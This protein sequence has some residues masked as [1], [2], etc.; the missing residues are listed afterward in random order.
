MLKNCA[1]L[2]CIAL[3]LNA[4]ELSQLHLVGR[5]EKSET[6]FVGASV[7]DANGRT[8]A[9]IKVISDLDGFKYTSYNGVVK[10]DDLPGQDLVYISPDE[11]VLEVFHGGFEPLKLIFSE[12]G[13]APSERRIWA[14][15]VAG[16]NQ[17]S[18]ALSIGILVTPPGAEVFIDGQN[19]GTGEQ[20]AVSAGS[21]QLRLVKSGYQPVEETIQV[22]DKRILFKYTMKELEPVNVRVETEPIGAKVFVDGSLLGESPA[23][24]FLPPGRYPLRIEKEWY[25][26]LEELLDI[27]P[28]RVKKLYNLQPTFAELRVT[29]APISGLAIYLDGVKQTAST[30]A[31]LKPLRPGAYKVEA[32]SPD[33][34]AT[35]VVEVTLKQGEQREVALTSMPSYALLT[36]RS[37]LGAKVTLNGTEL[38]MFENIRLQPALVTVRAEMAKAAPVER[39]IM[40]R[41]GDNQ[42]IELIPEVPRGTI[43][44]SAV[45]EQAQIEL[46]GDAGEFY[47]AKG[48]AIFTNIPVGRYALEVKH[49]GYVAARENLRLNQG[50][51]IIRNIRLEMTAPAS[52]VSGRTTAVEQAGVNTAQL[53]AIAGNE[54]AAPA[55]FVP[56]EKEPVVVKRVEPVYP[57]IAKKAGIEGTVWVKLWVDKTGK[58]RDVV[59]LKSSAEILNQPAIDAAKQWVFTP[60][61][62][63]SGPVSVWI[64]LS[65]NFRHK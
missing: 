61:L 62:M 3:S 32:R 38:S 65:F 14:V 49:Q 24:G 41:K 7:R 36:I 18:G 45:P 4:Q 29:S 37:V 30:P 55:D 13:I 26:T 9:A 19:R 33:Y 28:P 21:H 52:G 51:R 17:K 20:H 60:A 64:S 39:Q 27:Q 35:N 23:S 63:K 54:D 5:P 57:D 44:V 6:E 22:D 50:D 48:D 12:V 16:N 8:C 34:E 43:M 58:V 15:R 40:L 1:I 59:V 31:T 2:F 42:T 46:Q 53:D 10:V 25:V 56:F 47:Q 11:Q